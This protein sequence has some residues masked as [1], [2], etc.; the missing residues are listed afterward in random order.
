MKNHIKAIAA[1]SLF[2][3]AFFAACEKEK[4]GNCKNDYEFEDADVYLKVSN[5]ESKIISPLEKPADFEY[6]TKGTIEYS[7]SGTALATVD[8]GDGTKDTW[9]VKTVD[10][11]S[12]NIDLAKKG[13]PSEYE[14]VIVKPLVKIQGCD[15]IVEG[16]IKYFKNGEWAAT[17]DYGDGTCDEWAVKEWEGGSKK[18]SLAKKK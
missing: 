4:W 16:I 1:L 6:Y 17:V 8:F 9:A 13:K 14:K 11:N 10:G 12:G 2:H 5:Y 18:F 3:L 15:Y 7:Q